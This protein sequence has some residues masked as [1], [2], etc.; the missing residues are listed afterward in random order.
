[1]KS[2]I[3]GYDKSCTRKTQCIS[4]RKNKIGEYGSYTFIVI[5]I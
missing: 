2:D 1:M 5:F 3:T 4:L